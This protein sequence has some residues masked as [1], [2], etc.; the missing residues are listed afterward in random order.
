MVVI[1]I[2]QIAICVCV[3]CIIRYNRGNSIKAAYKYYISLVSDQ[4]RSI[5][6]SNGNWKHDDVVE[7]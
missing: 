1:N 6:N 3:C 2:Q 7:Q 5:N 4:Y